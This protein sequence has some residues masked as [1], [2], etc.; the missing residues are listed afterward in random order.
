MT[1]AF[2]DL[3]DA[4]QRAILDGDDAVLS[5][6]LDSPRENR[7]VLFDVYR[8]AYVLRLVEILQRDFSALHAHLGDADFDAVARAYVAAHPSTHRNARWLGNDLPAFLA[9]ASP[10]SDYPALAEIAALEAALAD[11]FDAAD[12]PVLAFEDF[13][14]IAAEDWPELRFKAHPSARRLDFATNASDIWSA[15]REDEAQPEVEA[16][17][18]PER[19]I[20][21]RQELTPMVRPMA[22][23]EAM[24]WDEATGKVPFGVLCT[25]LATFADPDSAAARAAGYLQGWVSAGMLTGVSVGR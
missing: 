4:V 1:V 7:A 18:E 3:Q 10:F 20:V 25:L 6:I 11:A 22:A 24:M 5:E 2:A 21:W 13:A 14:S 23:E 9:A 12:A 19:L 8:N 15:V 16:L 17:A